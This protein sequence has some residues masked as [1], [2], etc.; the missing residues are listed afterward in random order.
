MEEIE[1]DEILIVQNR[2]E[3][4][5]DLLHDILSGNKSLSYSSLKNFAESPEAFI[6]YCLKEK[7]QTD[8]MLFGSIVHCLV[9]EP[10]KFSERY[11]VLDDAQIVSEIGGGNPRA[12]KVYKEWKAIQLAN[13]TGKEMVKPEVF[14]QAEAIANNVSNNRASR[15]VLARCNKFEIPIEWEYNNF[16]FRGFKD[17]EGKNCMFDLKTMKSAEPRKAQ[18]DIIEMKYYLQAAMYLTGTVEKKPYYIIAVDKKGGVS[19][20]KINDDL[21]EYGLQEYKKLVDSFNDCLL[22]NHFNR[23][24]DYWS[25]L[26]N[27]IFICERPAYLYKEQ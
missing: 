16:K 23:S 15:A 21:M 3:K 8:A 7:K 17:A 10:M 12:T 25:Q 27:G 20:H 24:Y 9:L 11:F 26:E 22:R 1:E 2:D 6:Q 14:R 18:R 4:I 19:V 13:N 5:K